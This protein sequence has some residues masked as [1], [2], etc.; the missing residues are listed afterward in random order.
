M[1]ALNPVLHNLPKT[2]WRGLKIAF[3]LA[4]RGIRI[5]GFSLGF[6]IL[7]LLAIIWTSINQTSYQGDQLFSQP[8]DIQGELTENTLLVIRITGRLVEHIDSQAAFEAQLRNLTDDQQTPADTDARLLVTAINQAAHDPRIKG[9]VLDLISFSGASPALLAE[10]GSALK[11]FHEQEKKIIAIGQYL[12]QDGYYLASHSDFIML[13]PFGGI[14]L[15]GFGAHRM[16]MAEALAHLKLSVHTFTA[17]DYKSAPE[18]FTEQQMS[19]ASKHAAQRWLG[20]LWDH[21]KMTVSQNLEKT[22]NAL[23]NYADF[24]DTYF[25]QSQGNAALTALNLELVDAIHSVGT[26]AFSDLPDLY[27]E[28]QLR[29]WQ[30]P[31]ETPHLSAISWNYYHSLQEGGESAPL[32]QDYIAVLF[33]EGAIGFS[34]GAGNMD[35]WS[36]SQQIEGLAAQANPPNALVI[37]INSPG[38]SLYASEVIRRSIDKLDIPVIASVGGVGASGGY[39]IATAADEIWAS[40]DSITGSIGVFAVLLTAEQSIQHLGLNYDGVGTTALSGSKTPFSPLNPKLGTIFKSSVNNAY[41]EFKEL[42]A[43]HRNMTLE[44]VEKWAQGQ[45]WTGRQAVQ[46]NL[47]DGIGNFDDSIKAAARLAQLSEGDYRVEVVTKQVD[48]FHTLFNLPLL[49]ML[50]LESG[51]NP[52]EHLTKLLQVKEIKRLLYDPDPG[53]LYLECLECQLQKPSINPSS[54]LLLP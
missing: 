29:V 28:V 50:N 42:V 54:N 3:G 40:P 43:S 46:A 44:D 17:G 12:P 52:P 37:R 36:L 31:E 20:D 15:E 8:A 1:V 21:W 5:L 4:L 47:L 14:D 32:Q 23:Q 35:A 30:E 24:P 51:L 48:L 26:L 7:V 18:V 2:L 11:R 33:A 22:P 34:S 25:E 19:A 6:L 53:H 13:D 10:V 41:L 38:G 45:V 16:F 49:Q 27:R 9:A 39:Y